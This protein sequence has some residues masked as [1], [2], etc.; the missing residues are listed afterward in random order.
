MAAGDYPMTIFDSTTDKCENCGQAQSSHDYD[1]H[2]LGACG[3]AD[4]ARGDWKLV[5]VEPTSEMEDAAR[6]LMMWLDF[7]RPTESALLTHCRMLGKTPPPECRDV[8]HV[9]PKAMRLFWVYRAMIEA[10]PTR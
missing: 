10:S 7:S 6:H 4:L 2:A 8:D 1:R 3:S 9:P 5:P